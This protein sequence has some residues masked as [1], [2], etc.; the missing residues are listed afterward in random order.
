M[1]IG[2][3]F[4]GI[5]NVY[6]WRGRLGLRLPDVFSGLWRPTVASGA[7]ALLLV[8]QPVTPL[9]ASSS[10][11]LVVPLAAQVM[12]GVASYV[13]LVCFLWILIGRPKGAESLVIDALSRSIRLGAERWRRRRD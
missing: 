7:M 6:F 13:V 10:L 2:A 4:M 11:G 9:T 5:P 3:L 1:L 12:I 8:S